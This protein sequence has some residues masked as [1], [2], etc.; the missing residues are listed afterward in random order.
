MKEDDCLDAALTAEGISQ[1]KE[2]RDSSQCSQ[3]AC[4]LQLLLSSPLS[5][6]IDTADLVF[7]HRSPPKRIIL[8]ELREING[9]LLNGKRREKSALEELYPHWDFSGVSNEEDVDWT[10]D[11]LE[12][13]ESVVARGLR[14]LDL[15]WEREETEIAVIAHGGFFRKLFSSP[16][17]RNNNV[18]RF[19][20]CEC[21]AL[22]LGRKDGVYDVEQVG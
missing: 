2:A 21:K 3:A 12:S 9:L 18:A 22:K 19:S 16:S 11:E 7:P 10:A 8:E 15:I 1:A 4:N 13:D 6:C 14:A 5:R 20:N 17:I